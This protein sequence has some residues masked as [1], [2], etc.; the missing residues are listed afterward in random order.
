[1]RASLAFLTVWLLAGV[2]A[3]IGSVVG[4]GAGKPGLF[5]G[6]GLG[7]IIGVAAGV[8]LASRVGW[9]LATDR[10]GAL[11]GGIVGFAIAV[12]IAVSSLGTPII[13][14]FSCGLAGA[15]ALAG[16]AIA[17]GWQRSA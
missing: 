11:V 2:G 8:A 12:P 17:R 4:H 14:V 16:L 13:P 1:M 6:A 3:V 10:R 9:L 15:G 5:V 7:G